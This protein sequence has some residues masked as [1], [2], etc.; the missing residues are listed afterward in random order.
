MDYQTP[1]QSAFTF[2][3]LFALIKR[4]AYRIVLFVLIAVFVVGVAGAAVM[5]ATK[6]ANQTVSAVVDF[7]FEG[8]EEGKDPHG[9]TFD[10]NKI[11][12]PT[13]VN[14][15]IRALNDGK[16]KE[17]Q[18]DL[19]YQDTI[20]NNIT[21][22]GIVPDDIL[23][24]IVTLQQIAQSKPD[25]LSQLNDIKFYPSRYRIT[26]GDF[27]ECG[28]SRGEAV[29]LVDEIVAQYVSYFKK[30]YSEEDLI[31]NITSVNFDSYDY[32]EMI[33][34]YDAQLTTMYNYVNAKKSDAPLFRAN[35]TSLTFG[36]LLQQIDII[37][38]TDLF[39][40]ESFVVNNGITKGDVDT[41]VNYIKTSIANY[42][43]QYTKYQTDV[44]NL[45]DAIND[46]KLGD[47]IIA[48]NE[49]GPITGVQGGPTDQYNSLTQQRVDAQNMLSTIRQQTKILIDR[50]Q[51]FDP[52]YVYDGI[53]FE[54][55][56]T[57]DLRNVPSVAPYAEKTDAEI[58]ANKTSANEKIVA[59]NAKIEALTAE[60][61]ATVAEYLDTEYFAN[62]VSK[63][64]PAVYELNQ[65]SNLQ[66]ILLLGAVAVV[67]AFT[68]AV[69]VTYQKEKKMVVAAS[70]KQK[71][72]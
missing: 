69:V 39:Q 4:S 52:S 7:N 12:A 20:I 51:K 67:L 11:K 71:A 49:S 28:L 38:R 68:A 60:L 33:D 44:K 37:R 36:D 48:G 45:T 41:V 56:T 8:I 63:S 32:I 65:S 34:L 40:L 19:K 25:V 47:I 5:I 61:N 42:E 22:Q 3:Q 72:E 50:I 55:T 66:M 17:D 31:A 29:R 14:A 16:K 58:A 23:K 70:D 46:Y 59:I 2:R 10:A 13:V 24:Q 43:A 54:E 9:K 6:D 27:G 57:T 62:A 30:T 18:I 35:A 15:A 26:L 64:I 53:I 21:V 1:E